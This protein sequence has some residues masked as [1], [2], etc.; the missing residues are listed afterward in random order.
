MRR[1]FSDAD[2]SRSWPR[3]A[4][5]LVRRLLGHHYTTHVRELDSV[6]WTAVMH[7]VVA[8]S[9]V[10]RLESSEVESIVE[11]DPSTLTAEQIQRAMDSAGGVQERAW[12]I[13]G[14]RNRYQLIRLLKKHELVS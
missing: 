8:D 10:L 12:R 13:L 11:V 9:D 6:L 4:P 3:V 2:P 7:S 1:L 5:E 14:L